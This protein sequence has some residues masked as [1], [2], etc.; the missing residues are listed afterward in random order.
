MKDGK[1]AESLLGVYRGLDLADEKGQLCGRILADLGAE[2]VKV[3][4]PRG[5]AARNIKP[6]FGDVPHPG[7][8]LFWFAYNSN[9][10]SITL[11]IEKRDGQ[12]L[13]LP[14]RNSKTPATAML[15]AP[16]L[17]EH[18]EYVCTHL[19]GMPDDEFLDLY[20]TGIFG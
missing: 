15:P 14:S 6:F 11:D 2:V 8:S 16:C 12:E 20:Q 7:R 17:G 3:E 5:D 13:F 19:L 4:R 9:K 1:T 18:T 10:K